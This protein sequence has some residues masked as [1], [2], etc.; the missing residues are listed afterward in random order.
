MKNPAPIRINTA[1]AAVLVTATVVLMVNCAPKSAHDGGGSVET[2][3]LAPTTLGGAGTTDSGGG[4]GL[5][6]EEMSKMFEHFIKDPTKELAYI[7]HIAPIV[8]NLKFSEEQPMDFE[9]IF[10]MKTWY[11]APVDFEKMSKESLGVS[12][13]KT[14]TVQIA[15]QTSRS[16]WIKKELYDEQ[17]V[18]EAGSLEQA[19]TLMHEFVMNLYFIKFMPAKDLC[20]FEHF[21]SNPK[22]CAATAELLEK[23]IPAESARLLNEDDN[24][25]IRVMTAWLFQNGNR[26]MS[27]GELL[28]TFYRNGFDRRIFA[29][30]FFESRDERLE[31]IKT[32]DR[33]I[34]LAIQG[35]EKAGQMPSV[36]KGSA[37]GQTLPCRLQ[38]EAATTPL[39][40]G[41]G[42]ILSKGLKLSITVDGSRPLEFT[43]L[44][45][46]ELTLPA[47]DDGRGGIV[48]QLTT[49]EFPSEIRA[50]DRL[51]HATLWFRK[52][53]D[54]PHAALNLESITV[55]SAQVVSVDKNRD[56]IC[57]V[58]T[59]EVKTFADDQILI[60]SR[61][62]KFN[63]SEDIYM[64]A[65]PIGTCTAGNIAD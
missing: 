34:L 22:T 12:F 6:D 25:N 48:Y 41:S 37:S 23:M 47:S 8:K 24:E 63:L 15:R 13:L 53:N 61:S 14:S 36:C 44:V 38:I 49:I 52:E 28:Q 45:G 64:T 50:G 58:R 56:P 26:K 42:T 3:V 46:D 40:V 62:A 55:R 57:L 31:S 10:K 32:S 43:A 18:K 11:F 60:R 35:T 54:G 1:I 33:E 20:K 7:K 39:K 29:P 9:A 17:A 16:V 27:Q 59:P 5:R 4:T 21:N 65:P 30:N 19:E 2:G 51:H